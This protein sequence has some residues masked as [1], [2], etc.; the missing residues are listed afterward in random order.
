LVLVLKNLEVVIPLSGMI[1]FETESKR[2]ASELA[3]TASQVDRLRAMLGNADFAAKAPP[4]VVAKE[5]AKLEA[6]EDKL[7]RLKS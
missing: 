6:L 2:Q 7:R 5:K 1:D 4:Q 3:E